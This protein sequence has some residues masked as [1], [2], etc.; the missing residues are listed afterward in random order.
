MTSSPAGANRALQSNLL[1]AFLLSLCMVRL[2]LMELPSSFWVDEM[3]TV[4]VVR[5]G[6]AHPSLAIAPQVPDSLYYWLPRASTRLLGQ[7][8][9]AYRIPSLLVAALTLFLI[10]RL[11]ARLIHPRAAWFAAFACLA[12][13]DFNDHAVD[14]RPY[15]LGICVAAAC[16]WCM[17]R[18][19]DSGR[20]RDGLLL[21]ACGA[22]LWPIHLIYWPF[23]IVLL[24]YTAVRLARRETPVRVP[25]ALA[26]FALM[27]LAVVPVALRALQLM[28]H[29]GAH[30]ILELPSLHHFEWTL[31]W[32]LVVLAGVLAWLLSRV[33]RWKRDPQ[34]FSA[35]S[36]VLV[37]AWWLVPAFALLAYSYITGNSV[38][39]PRY[40]SISIP[41]LVLSAAFVASPFLSA[42][43]WRPAAILVGISALAILGQWDSE[44]PP[45]Q[46]SDWRGAVA[47]VN[48]Q[49]NSPQTAVICTSPFVEGQPPN[50]TPDYPLPGFL[51]S[52]L[53]VY[54]VRGH[55]LL[56]P[57][58]R[59]P[60]SESYAA[61]L[62]PQTLTAPGR[63]LI[64]GGAGN[65]RDWRN[66][67]AERPE[68]AG[69]HHV[70]V[71]FG[72]VYVA[73]FTQQ[74]FT[75]THSLP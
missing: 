56:F 47:F 55:I 43:H 64:Y 61:G 54:P 8:E 42:A 21:V 20:L 7:S 71:R 74:S 68:L 12:I 65:V 70:L 63:F 4:F 19:L 34:P 23:Y 52:H 67:F 3:A 14:A 39:V 2:W 27:A 45:H 35:A 30:V 37:L 22:L 50:W 26:V 5:H 9:I 69:W 40:L 16:V 10:A 13:H 31:R 72:D 11:A 44:W 28:R 6:A 53:S 49:V 29:A 75:K 48:Q 36:L 33:F 15:S 1:L 24:A 32:K 46:H 57:F 25:Q 66:W 18:W 17:V 62:L 60:D 73:L 59:R 58:L 41:G 38:F 51:Y